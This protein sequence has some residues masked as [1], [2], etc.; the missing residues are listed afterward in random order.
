MGG[1]KARIIL[2]ETI[3]QEANYRNTFNVN[4]NIGYISPEY[5][6]LFQCIEVWDLGIEY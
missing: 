4:W 6:K 2:Y 1:T 5:Q 3:F